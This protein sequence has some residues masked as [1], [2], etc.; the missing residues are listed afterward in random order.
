MRAILFDFDYTL[1][2]SSE[3]I[4][5]C[6][7]AGL[8]GIGLPPADPEAI[9]RTIGLTLPDSLAEVAGEE[10]RSQSYEFRRHWRAMSKRVMVD[11][12]KLYEQVPETLRVLQGRG[13]RLGI[14][15]TK[16]R[17]PIEE[18]L[19]R[20][21]LTKHFE[22]IVGGD[23]VENHKPSPEGLLQALATMGVHCREALYVGDSVID[24]QTARRAG[25]RFV[26]VLTGATPRAALEELEPVGV[27]D[28]VGEIPSWL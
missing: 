20:H 1:A 17:R 22:T 7:Q 18:V 15:S 14:V 10:H 21:G 26:A 25:V 23:D 27:L 16:W 19:G 24:G 13:S 5:A 3:G 12:T 8:K 4:T 9:R 2:D 11:R 6:F 28:N